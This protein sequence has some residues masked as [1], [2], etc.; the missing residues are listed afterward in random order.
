M[1]KLLIGAFVLVALYVAWGSLRGAP[2]PASAVGT[3]GSIDAQKARDRGAELGEKAAL[4]AEKVKAAA[5]DAATT[6]KIKAK[7]ALDEIVKARA[8]DVSSNGPTVTVSGTVHSRTEHDR[9]LLLARE[10]AGVTA[11]VDH[12][13]LVIPPQ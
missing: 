13:T 8:I 6:T 10:T 1:R 2:T 12:L 9:A 4:A 11:V 7:M 5:G 3:A